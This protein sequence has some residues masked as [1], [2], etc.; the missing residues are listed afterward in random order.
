MIEIDDHGFTRA[1]EDARNIKENGMKKSCTVL[2]VLAVAA[3]V[4]LPMSAKAEKTWQAGAKIGVTGAKLTGNQVGLYLSDPYHYQVQGAVGDKTMGFTGGGFVRMGF[5]DL[6]SLQLEA[7]YTQKGGEG[8]VYGGVWFQDTDG[9]WIEGE[10][11]GQMTISLDYV[12]F[13][14]LAMFTFDADNDG[15]VHLVGYGGLSAGVVARSVVNL[16]GQL[17]FPTGGGTK[18]IENFDQTYS[19]SNVVETFELAGVI[20]GGIEAE[21]GRVLLNFD[22]RYTF[23]I[24]QVNKEGGAARNS[25]VAGYVGVGIPF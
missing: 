18:V 9:T 22:F 7:L 13:P 11:D 16:A 19:L 17:A 2:A 12:E 8:N 24:T 14:L 5:S 10:L 15:D 1:K 25:V 3:M 6:F 23:G 20:G 21:A 4:I